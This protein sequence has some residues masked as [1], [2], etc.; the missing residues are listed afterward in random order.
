MRRIFFAAVLFC[1]SASLL[2]QDKDS[3]MIKR[4]SDEILTNG[5]AYSNLRFLCKQV[6]PRL[7][8]SAQAEKAV[9]ETARML[10]EVGADT[11][12]LQECMVP[13]W[14]RGEKEEAILKMAN[15]VKKPLKVTALGNSVG[16]SA[17]GI[18]AYVVEVRTMDELNQLGEAGI[19][20]KIVFFNHKMNP[21]FI[22]T[23]QAYGEAGI[24]RFRGPSMAAKYGAVGVIVRS[25]ASNLDDHPH[26]GATGYIDSFPKIP[27]VA[28][29]TNDAELLSRTLKLRMAPS[30]VY[31]KTNCKMMPD[32]KS[33]NVI[34]EIRGSEFPNE[35]ITVGGHLDS[36]DLAEGANDD[37]SGCVQSIEV[38]RAVKAL[39]VK[40]RR[41]IRAVMFMNEENG[42]KGATQYAVV[43]RTDGKKHIFALESDAGGFTP[44]GFSISSND[45]QKAKLAPWKNLLLPYGS[46]EF[47][48]FGGGADV[49]PLKDVGAVTAEL[50]PD[51][52]RYFDIHH[53]ETDV[54]ENVSPRELHLGA[55]NMAALVWLIS[56][57]GL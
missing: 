26:T 20:G 19:K 21:T 55:V 36:W 30:M 27:A 6:G 7:S 18:T 46:Y 52:Q 16:T 56:E 25:L 34:G 23:F 1:T 22:R 24:Y 17:A 4:I 38:I 51:S 5:T 45:A 8:G 41:T 37:G 53:A 2:A 40:P 44:R 47:H 48:D 28:I 49:S 54:F 35:V 31:F 10:K 12:W 15:G 3:V 42:L 29:S 9:R 57:Y 39:G 13:H 33:Y 43:A 50:L 32:V 14:V 11:V